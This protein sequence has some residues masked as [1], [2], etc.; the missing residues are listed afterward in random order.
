MDFRKV[1]D[2][3]IISLDKER[4]MVI[5]CDS[6]GGIGMKAGDVLK[7]PPFY[8]GK[9]TA[10]VPLLEVLCTGAEIVS[11][12]DTISNEM[13]PT[14]EEIIK[15]IEEELKEAGIDGVILTGSTEEN[16]KTSSTALGVTVIGIG[17]SLNLRVNSI[18]KEALL[19]SVGLP[20]VGGEINLVKDEDIVD[21]HI[22]KKLLTFDSVYE[23]V[24]VGSRGILYET[25]LLA[26]SNGAELFLEKEINV[27]I[28]KSGGPSTCLITAVSSESYLEISSTISNVNIIGWLR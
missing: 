17:S 14:G 28:Y 18:K 22:L 19:I 5:A 11:I 12:A 20:K 6:C 8:V 16:F 10:R 7:V 23:I 25:Q 26:E 4:A 15:G 13:K 24:P 2:L 27:D 21:Y 1:R 9:F 3:T